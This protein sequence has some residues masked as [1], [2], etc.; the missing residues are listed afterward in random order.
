VK[1]SKTKSLLLILILIISPALLSC[2]KKADPNKLMV[3]ETNYGRIVVEF[4]PDSAPQNIANVQQ[5]AEQ[6]FYNGTR[7]DRVGTEQDKRTPTAL[8][9][10]D[11]NTIND[12]E[13]AGTWG[14][15]KPG[16]KTVPLEQS[17]YTFDRGIIAAVRRTDDPNSA[18]S[19]F[20]IC[21]KGMPQWNG[22]YSVLGRVIEGMNVVDTIVRAM[23][24]RRFP[25]DVGPQDDPRYVSR[26]YLIN[27]DAY[28]Q[29]S[30]GGQSSSARP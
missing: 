27:R 2:A 7:F 19:Q 6:G 4:Y 23:M 1:L 22:Q 26:I 25:Q 10:G 5:L 15:G 29:Q 30:A 13:S 11:P 14:A 3:I 12:P 8:M 17:K 9:G 20:L 18:A 24:Q 16:Q 28:K 21:V